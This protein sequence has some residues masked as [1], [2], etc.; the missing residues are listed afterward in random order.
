MESST[1]ITEILGSNTWMLPTFKVPDPHHNP[2]SP[3][4]QIRLT[5]KVSN[6][7]F[8]LLSYISVISKIYII[9]ILCLK[10][11][12][13]IFFDRHWSFPWTSW[14]THGTHWM[15]STCTT[16]ILFIKLSGL[17]HEL[18]RDASSLNHWHAQWDACRGLLLEDDI[19]AYFWCYLDSKS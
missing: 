12:Q 19:D 14:L 9:Y 3:S 16:E 8:E 11:L 7:K 5:F 17:F 10:R 4:T 2:L 13:L 15:D 18:L 1:L 6:L